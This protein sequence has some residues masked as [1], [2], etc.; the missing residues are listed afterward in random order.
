M[1]GGG[2]IERGRAGG[3]GSVALTCELDERSRL[4]SGCFSGCFWGCASGVGGAIEFEPKIAGISAFSA[5]FSMGES[6]A[7]DFDSD[8]NRRTSC[9]LFVGGTT[10]FAGV[11]RAAAL[12]VA[13]GAGAIALV[14]W[15]AAGVAGVAGV[16][17]SALFVT[18]EGLAACAFDGDS[19]GGST[20]VVVLGAWVETSGVGVE[21]AGL[22]AIAG[23]ALLVAL[24]GRALTASGD[25]GGV[26]RA[27]AGGGTRID[28][29]AGGGTDV[30]LAGGEERVALVVPSSSS[31]PA[32]E[33]T[34][35]A[36]G[37]APSAGGWTA[38]SLGKCTAGI[39]KLDA[40]RVRAGGAAAMNTS[41]FAMDLSGVQCCPSGESSSS[42]VMR[43]SPIHERSSPLLGRAARVP[44]GRRTFHGR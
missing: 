13:A 14:A 38:S 35:G 6:G 36:A 25:N 3:V 16:V 40:R 26:D 2:G 11:G 27:A 42:G 29:D 21:C 23:G 33:G 44:F 30:A 37:T 31:I 34:F 22:C 1:L 8:A 20:T 15:C 5:T 18:G 17:K 43:P 28:G 7:A 10:L 19:S 12:G 32:S 24:T 39:A 9:S 4:G 41:R